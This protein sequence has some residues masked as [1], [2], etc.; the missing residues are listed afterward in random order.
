MAKNDAVP[1][2]EETEQKIRNQARSA[3]EKALRL[4]HPEEFQALYKVECEARGI[5]YVVRLTAEQKAAEQLAA[6]L[7]QFPHLK[8]QV[9]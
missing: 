4:A 7:E 8:D 2:A 9:G 6:I 5:P 1:T 3:A